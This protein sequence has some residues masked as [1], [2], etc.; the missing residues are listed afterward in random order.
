[1]CKSAGDGEG[2][3]WGGGR[4]STLSSEC[5]EQRCMRGF[6]VWLGGFRVCGFV[7]TCRRTDPGN[8]LI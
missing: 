3:D 8:H 4:D 6:R 5:T 2:L 7:D 1:M